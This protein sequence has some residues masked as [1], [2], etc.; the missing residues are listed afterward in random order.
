MPSK[1]SA[2]C[3]AMPRSKAVVTCRLNAL[4]R[5]VGRAKIVA[6]GERAHLKVRCTS[7][8]ERERGGA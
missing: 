8:V 6:D 3:P 2:N 4:V 7:K 5:A 1:S